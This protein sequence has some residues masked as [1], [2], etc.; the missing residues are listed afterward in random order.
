MLLALMLAMFVS[1]IIGQV[2]RINTVFNDENQ[3][4]QRVKVWWLQSYW[5]GTQSQH[6]WHVFK[7]FSL[8]FVWLIELT[9]KPDTTM[10]SAQCVCVLVCLIKLLLS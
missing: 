6:N 3:S 1:D 9:D 8:L 4:I 10:H 5:T 2:S 7:L